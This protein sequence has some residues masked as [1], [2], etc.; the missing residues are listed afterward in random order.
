[1][2]LRLRLFLL[3]A[4][5]VALLVTGQNLLVRSLAERLD[6]DVAV[7]AAHV[8]EEILAGFEFR[9]DEEEPP[10]LSGEHRVVVIT[11]GGPLG[12]GAAPS[13]KGGAAAPGAPT[14]RWQVDQE[15]TREGPDGGSAVRRERR[16]LVEPAGRDGVLLLRG[17]AFERPIP[18]PRS[19]VASTLDRFGSQLAAGS[20]ALLALGLVAAAV[21]AHRATRPLAGLAAAARR[22]GAGELGVA[23]PV[24][25]RDE[26]G[27]ALTAFNAMSARLAALDRENRRLAAV[28]HLSELGEVA[29]GLAHTLRNP[30]NALGLS[31]EQLAEGSEP[32]RAAALAE[33]SRRQIRRMDGALRSFLALASAS[34]AAPAPVDLAG[35]AREVALEA[36]QDAGGRVRLAVEAPV[37]VPLSGVEAEL[38][39]IVQAL[40]VNACEAS[41]DAGEVRLA[42]EPLAEGEGGARLVVEDGGPGLA[43]EVRQRL[44][45][46]HVTTKPHG[47]GMGLFLARRLAAGRYGGDVAL[48]DRPTGG[49]RAV[50]TLRGRGV[51]G[52]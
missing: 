7:V 43:P 10:A 35:V 37:P 5:L 8:G 50:V 27:E 49:T 3:L 42:V 30:L 24:E 25:R 52:A 12:E 21:L 34:E 40:V 48:A 1:M 39:A 23:V 29:R 38:K 2:T 47:S 4:A 31:V 19:P 17:P 18:V 28:E 14:V 36:L 32:E 20:L 51:T 46:P 41:P 9:T 13:A 45:A 15:W 22:L 33:A 16:V 6:Q 26:I 11:R 44:F